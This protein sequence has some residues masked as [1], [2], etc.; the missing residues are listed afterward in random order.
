VAASF[1]GRIAPGISLR[2]L[3]K[4]AWKRRIPVA[5]PTPVPAPA[6]KSGRPLK[7]ILISLGILAALAIVF[8]GLLAYGCYHIAHSVGRGA[9]SVDSSTL[10]AADLGTDIY[11]GARPEKNGTRVTLPTGSVTTGVYSTPDS[12]DQVEAFYKD[13]LGSDATD[14]NAGGRVI[15]SKRVSKTETVTVTA[16]SHAD[17]MDGRTKIMIAEVTSIVK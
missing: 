13:K 8:V 1:P 9:T 3:L 4:A 16:N 6:P 14:V 15:L 10:T 17:D 7:I 5:T 2:V 12:V 11:P